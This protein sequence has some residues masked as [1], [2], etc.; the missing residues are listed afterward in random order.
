MLINHIRTALRSIFKQRLYSAISVIGLTLALT[1]SIM[2]ALFIRHELSFDTSHPDSD[3]L[4][5]LNW[6]NVGAG[7][8]FA[9]FFNP[10]AP[11]LAEGLP[12][13]ESFSRLAINQHLLSIDNQKQYK[14][15]SFVDNDFFKLF[16][17]PEISGSTNSIEDRSSAVITEAAALQLFGSKDAIGETFTV[18]EQFDFRVSAIVRDNP[19]NS[20]LV[21]NIFVN[22]ENVPTLWNN[23][24]IWENLGSDVMYSYVRLAPG[25]NIIDVQEKSVN[26]IVE[27]TEIGI[28][29]LNLVDIVL[30]PV[31]SIHFTSDLQN[32]MTIQDDITGVVKPIRQPTDI[33]IFAAVAALTLTIAI[34]N[35][36]NLQ[37]VQSS[38]RAR[39]VGVRRTM[40]ASS[41]TL[42]TQFLVETLILSFLALALALFVSELLI[43]Y[44][45]VM[46]AVPLST[47]S[48][49]SFS[50]L[51]L[52]VLLTLLVALL[53]GA[54]P[55]MIIAR[56]G[57][58]SA[59]KGE[60]AKTVSVSK[61]RAGLIVLQFS[62][63]IGLMISCGVISNQINFALSKNLGFS[64]E[65]VVT[66]DLGNAQA[67]QQ[68]Q[69]MKDQLLAEVNTLSV[70]AGSIIPTQS[71][72][73]GATFTQTD[74]EVTLAARRV[75]VSDGYFDTLGMSFIAGR[76][77]SDDFATDAMPT[78]GEENLVVS[79]GVV[80][81]ETA[82]R[83]AGWENLQDAIGQELYSE[84]GFSGLNFRM[85][86]RVVGIVN[87][88]H[89]GSVR[90]EIG[91]V[92]YTLDSNRNT[93]IIK[94]A[95]GNV[96]D[97]LAS[98]DGVWEQY[99]PDFPIRRSFLNE[100]YSAFYAGENRTF[101]LFIGFAAIAV[102]VACLGLYG[103][104][105][106]MAERRYK[107]ISIRKVLGATV[108]SIAGLLAWD[109]SK[110]VILA[111]LV[112]WPAA[113]WFMQGWLSSFAYRTEI[114][115]AIFFLAG[116]TT[117]ILA[118]ATTF[119]RAY[120]VAVSNPVDALRAE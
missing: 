17:V 48:L 33:I 56:L 67:R 79:G 101:I 41:G 35:F 18:D 68:Y 95:P 103:L 55:A 19:S 115:F 44:F 71:L 75:S 116:L 117:F 43:P 93:M 89:F 64:A 52:A 102:L 2:I 84:F 25:S 23:A 28:E 9:T 98:I 100:S 107:E 57:P 6:I 32:E 10:I 34:F 76:P 16:D 27:N 82:A 77:L 78:L 66:V 119:Q 62:I 54:Y 58:V 1:V 113:W 92:S 90:T 13:I 83:A 38:K 59:L 74:S 12:E 4:Y 15:I 72:S 106:F 31:T 26:Y 97:T 36:M 53:S 39:E 85:N 109:F 47:N 63:S 61:F 7:A 29:F 105:S 73:D 42:A 65:N 8:H 87:D 69:S 21:S 108:R 24:D 40:G 99:V 51:M 11:L 96:A 50:S 5:R 45:S 60:V 49:F 104:A 70:S 112:A 118:L 111:N 81:N 37:I 22:I 94:I 110:L 114:N 120:S 88:A 80:F 14:N 20:H 86:Y 46:L 91:P 3:R 30:Q